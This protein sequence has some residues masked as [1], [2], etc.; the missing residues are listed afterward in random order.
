M[1]E[2]VF[3]CKQSQFQFWATKVTQTHPYFSIL[4]N[5]SESFNYLYH[6]FLYLSFLD[7]RVRLPPIFNPGQLKSGIIWLLNGL[8]I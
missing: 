7:L 1:F 3:Q 2:K 4:V 8:N 6:S 5:Y